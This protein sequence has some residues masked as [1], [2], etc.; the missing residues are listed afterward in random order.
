MK[1]RRKKRQEYYDKHKDKITKTHKEYYKENKKE[2]LEK[3]KDKKAWSQPQHKERI[4]MARFFRKR[5]ALD[6]MH[7]LVKEREERV[8]NMPP[9]ELINLV[10]GI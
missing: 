5:N 10:G 7:R 9:Q 3:S 2:L 4:E 8:K 6:V 1:T